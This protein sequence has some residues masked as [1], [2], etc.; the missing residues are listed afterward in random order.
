MRR[1]ATFLAIALGAASG[2]QAAEP[3]SCEEYDRLSRQAIVRAAEASGCVN[4]S[5]S[6]WATCMTGALFAGEPAALSLMAL[7]SDIADD[8]AYRACFPERP[9][10]A[11]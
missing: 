11:F 6:A 8:E 7:M 3:T 4:M 9:P 2:A 1:H 10:I 5:E